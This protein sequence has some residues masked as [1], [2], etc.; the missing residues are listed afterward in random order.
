VLP[1]ADQRRYGAAFREIRSLEARSRQV[2][3]LAGRF[4]RL[5][6]DHLTAGRLEPD[7][8]TSEIVQ[9]SDHSSLGHTEERS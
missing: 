2:A 9:T 1:L 8:E 6:S 7:T 3:N 4:L 5:L